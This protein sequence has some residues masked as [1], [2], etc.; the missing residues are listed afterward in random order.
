MKKL[1][2]I[3]LSIFLSAFIWTACQKD[4][5]DCKAVTTNNSDGSVVQNGSSSE[6]CD[7]ALDDKENAEPVNDGSTTTKWVCE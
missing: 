5:K 3:A 6:Y 7:T 1:I 4:C 2:I